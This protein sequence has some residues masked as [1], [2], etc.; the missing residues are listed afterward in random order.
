[1]RR[2]NSF[3][4][5]GILL[6]SF[7]TTVQGQDYLE[8]QGKAKITI[9]DT[10]NTATNIVVKQADGTLAVRDASTFPDADTDPTNELELP[11]TPVAGEMVYWDGS[12]WV[13]IPPGIDGQRLTYCD[14]EPI[15]GPCSLSLQIGDYHQGGIVFFLDASGQHGLVAAPS[16]QVM[17]TQWGCQGTEILG[18]QG[19]AVG[20]GY[21]NT[22]DI[23]NDCSTQGTAADVCASLVLNGY[24]DWF[25]PSQDELNLMYINLHTAGLGNFGIGFY[26][27]STEYISF[28]AYR[29]YFIDGTQ[30]N[31]FKDN[32]YR[33]RAARFF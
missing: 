7:T 2:K 26:W 10:D 23:L 25:L 30:S 17:G 11:A 16:D 3:Q 29:Q 24:S 9:M 27:S 22:V 14:G 12:N 21:Q 28:R 4:L 20:T 6:I 31:E 32:N 15:W 33:V 13:G 18:A 1:M 5:I 19:T 8:I